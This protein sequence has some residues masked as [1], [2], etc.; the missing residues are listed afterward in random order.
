MGPPH[1]TPLTDPPTS[2]TPSTPTKHPCF[3]PAALKPIDITSSKLPTLRTNSLAN[4]N[5]LF[6]EKLSR[7]FHSCRAAAVGCHLHCPP[8]NLHLSSVLLAGGPPAFPPFNHLTHD[9]IHPILFSTDFHKNKLSYKKLSSCSSPSNLAAQHL[10]NPCTFLPPSL[11]Q[12][13]SS[14]RLP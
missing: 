2:T 11:P 7:S 10:Q 3:P 12:T 6:C 14:P 5:L 9:K 13:P 4:A 1:T 8:A